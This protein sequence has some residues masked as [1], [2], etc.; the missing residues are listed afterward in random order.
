M[1]YHLQRHHKAHQEAQQATLPSYQHP[2]PAL[3]FRAL[4]HR[5]RS[6]F[7]LLLRQL[8]YAFIGRQQF[9]LFNGDLVEP[10]EAFRLRQGLA[11]EQG[12]EVFEVGEA[13][14]LGAGGLV[15]NVAFGF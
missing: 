3:H 11:D 1:E 8:G 13:N 15:A 2:E 14:E 9:H 7:L 5:Y 6:F 4:G 12:V 10:G